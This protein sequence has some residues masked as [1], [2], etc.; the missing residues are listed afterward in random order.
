M[1]GY[2]LSSLSRRRCT[3]SEVRRVVLARP[4]RVDTMGQPS[5]TSVAS[6]RTP[7]G[8]MEQ[9]LKYEITRLAKKQLQATCVPLV[10][11]VRQLKRTVSQLRKTVAFLVPVGAQLQAQKMAEMAKLEAA[12]ESR[13]LG[14]RRASSRNS[15]RGAALPKANWPRSLVCRSVRLASG[16][17]GRPSPKAAAGRCWSLC[18]NWASTRWQESARHAAR[19]G[20]SVAP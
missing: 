7:M 4:Q 12:P 3:F 19:K 16:S 11:E 13:Q 2:G 5:T 14:F 6:R 15:V 17:M 9:A 8:K 10:R 18:G 1:S 20:T